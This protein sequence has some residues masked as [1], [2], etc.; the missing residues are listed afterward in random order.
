[1]GYRLTAG[2]SDEREAPAA[3]IENHPGLEAGR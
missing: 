3:T 2:S 1:V